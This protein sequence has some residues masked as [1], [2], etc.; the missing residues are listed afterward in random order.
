LTKGLQQV[1]RGKRPAKGRLTMQKQPQAQ[2]TLGGTFDRLRQ[3]AQ[4]NEG[5]N[6][7]TGLTP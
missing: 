2:T 4:E 6:P 1:L 7:E 5:V 3:G